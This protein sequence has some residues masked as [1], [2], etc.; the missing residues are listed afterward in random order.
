MAR[1]MMGKEFFFQSNKIFC[2]ICKKSD[3]SN[4]M[5]LFTLVRQ[6]SDWLGDMDKFRA[7]YMNPNVLKRDG[8]KSVG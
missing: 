8:T 6:R 4:K 3:Q 2:R 1:Q 5:A 7:M